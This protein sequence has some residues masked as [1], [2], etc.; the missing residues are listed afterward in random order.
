VH[1]RGVDLHIRYHAH[2]RRHTVATATLT[3]TPPTTRTD[4]TRLGPDE[5][6]SASIFDT[7]APDPTIAIGAVQGAA[8]TFTSDV[9]NVGVH[10]FTVITNDTTG[11]VSASSNVASVTV[12]AVLANPSAVADLAATLNP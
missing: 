10:N 9:L 3:W 7:A 2:H 1:I 8:G 12:P 6:A 4:G 11:H 5:I